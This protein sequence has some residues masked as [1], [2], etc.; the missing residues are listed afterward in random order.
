MQAAKLFK[1]RFKSS[2][3]HLLDAAFFISQG[4]NDG[5]CLIA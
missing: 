4:E 1:V 5:V 3:P 2:R